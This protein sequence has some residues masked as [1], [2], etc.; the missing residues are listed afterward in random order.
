[1]KQLKYSAFLILV[2]LSIAGVTVAQTADQIIADY[3][4]NAGGKQKWE[5]LQ[6]VTMHIKMTTN[7]M[8]MTGTIY[9]K[10]PDKHKSIVN[11]MNKSIVSAYDGKDA[12]IKNPFLPDSTAQPAPEQ[13]ARSMKQ[14]SFEPEFL[15][16]AEKGYTVELTGSDTL[17]GKEVY[18]IKL[19]KKNGNIEYHY[20]D[21]ESYLPVMMK[22][23][24]ASGPQKGTEAEVYFSDFRK[25]DGL[26]FPFFMESQ[27]GGTTVQKIEVSKIELNKPMDDSMFSFPKK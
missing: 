8:E 7:G 14:N 10:R 22:A 1:M 15:N 18:E 9:S 21:K 26:T 3:F 11:V 24:V 2:F 17:N 4:K 27:S 16:Y 20:F 6:T 5:N 23:F 13:M 12:W 19:T 25:V